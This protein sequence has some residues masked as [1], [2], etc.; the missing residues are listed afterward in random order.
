[1][2]SLTF[3]KLL[4]VL[5]VLG[6]FYIGHGLHRTA[7]VEFPSISQP[8]FAADQN[9]EADMFVWEQV[10]FDEKQN[11]LT[12]RAKIPGGWLVVVRHVDR[13][14]SGTGLTFVPEPRHGWGGG[15]SK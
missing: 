2:R 9:P 13:E 6:L 7:N 4:A 5:V 11:T 12:R 10:D 8:A 3:G 14:R 1:M 15:T